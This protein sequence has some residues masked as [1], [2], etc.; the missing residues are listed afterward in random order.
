MNS[1]LLNE[2]IGKIHSNTKVEIRPIIPFPTPSLI[3]QLNG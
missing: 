2:I 3:I 1:F